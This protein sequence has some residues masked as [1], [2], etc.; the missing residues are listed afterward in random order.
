MGTYS[1]Q[2]KTHN[3]TDLTEQYL[4]KLCECKVHKIKPRILNI[5]AGKRKE[6]HYVALCSDDDCGKISMESA[7]EVVGFWNKY[8][9]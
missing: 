2:L 8:N 1:V 3:R 9:I 4:D 6:Q 7:D 5:V